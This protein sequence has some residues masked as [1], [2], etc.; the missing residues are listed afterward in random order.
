MKTFKREIEYPTLILLCI[1]ALLVLVI[2]GGTLW[3]FGSGRALSVGSSRMREADQRAIGSLLPETEALFSDM[4]ILRARTADKNPIVIVI[5][6]V[7]PYGAQDLPFR[8]ELVSKNRS[9]RVAVLDWFSS[10]TLKEIS[11]LG[12]DRVKVELIERINSLLVLGKIDRLWFSDY[13]VL[14]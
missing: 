11:S 7:F 4:G 3:A 1:A 2:L 8:E 13:M 14:D 9:M 5:S 12:E 10:R 6:P